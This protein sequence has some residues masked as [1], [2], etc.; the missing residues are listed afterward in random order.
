M[1]ESSVEKVD[2]SGPWSVCLLVPCFYSIWFSLLKKSPNCI[3]WQFKNILKFEFFKNHHLSFHIHFLP[4]GPVCV[5]SHICD[6]M[7]Y[8]L[9]GSSVHGIFH[10][11]ILEWFV[12]YYSRGSSQPRDQ[13]RVSCIA[14]RFFTLWATR[15]DYS[16]SC[17]H[18][19][20]YC[21]CV[22]CYLVYF[23]ATPLWHVGS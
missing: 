16:C 22:N 20:E 8:S 3:I 15:E 11:R 12:I 9:P 4:I 14:G 19:V 17:S 13:T 18:T 5:L 2:W 1:L 23:L 21:V 10:R 6:P 7:N